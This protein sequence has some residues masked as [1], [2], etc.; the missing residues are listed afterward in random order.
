MSLAGMAA[1][2]FVLS[3]HTPYGQWVVYRRKHLL[4]GC[5]KSDP[6]TY[7]LAKAVV[8]WLDE[9]LPDAEARVARAPAPS[10]LASLL[11]TDQLDVA[12]LGWEE[13]E[14]MRA[15]EEIFAAYGEIPLQVLT[16]IGK[17][18]LI[19]HERMPERHV[20]LVAEALSD[21]EQVMQASMPQGTALPWH[22]GAALFNNGAPLPEE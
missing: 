16:P 3:G 22:S 2:A 1:A 6:E 9:H 13:A 7:E 14:Q 17:H 20:W 5:H 12:I 4:I 19:A 15:G 18:V 10:R 8:A 21:A 11:G